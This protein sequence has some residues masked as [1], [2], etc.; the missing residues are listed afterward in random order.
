MRRA[1]AHISGLALVLFLF[2]LALTLSPSLHHFFHHDSDSAG[3]TC[4]VTIIASGQVLS[5]HATSELP[6]LVCALLLLVVSDFLLPYH[7]RDLRFPI[8]RAP[9]LA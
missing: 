1:K 2:S 5:T 8:G 4:I 6:I 7:E 3:H 9:P